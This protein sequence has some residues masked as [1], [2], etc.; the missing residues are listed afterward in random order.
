MTEIQTKKQGLPARLTPMQR[1]FAALLVFT[2]GHKFAYEC[3]KEAGY[4]GDNATL[5][6]TA[7]RL[8]NPRYFPLVVKHIGELREENY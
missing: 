3:D 4:E 2:E 5:R 6:M 7:S 8:Q 1:K